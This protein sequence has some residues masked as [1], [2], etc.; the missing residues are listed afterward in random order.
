M[1]VAPVAD[2]SPVL[3][4]IAAWQHLPEAVKAG[5]AAMVLAAAASPD[6]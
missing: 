1:Y 4:P 5:I 2:R 6:E 3:A